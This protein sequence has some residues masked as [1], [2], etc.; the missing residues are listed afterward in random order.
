M[1]W[2]LLPNTPESF[3]FTNLN[4]VGLPQKRAGVNPYPEEILN[5][6][7]VFIHYSWD[8]FF[9]VG[10]AIKKRLKGRCPKGTRG[11]RDVLFSFA[12][13][14][15]PSPADSPGK[16]VL[17]LEKDWVAKALFAPKKLEVSTDCPWKAIE[18]IIPRLRLQK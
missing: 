15:S 14:P 1:S 17:S 16:F 11:D 4:L 6:K 3:I 7:N 9:N 12:Y 10:S 13:E 8:V 2:R 18:N 5:A